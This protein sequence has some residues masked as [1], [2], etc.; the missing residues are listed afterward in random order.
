MKLE[1]GCAPRKRETKLSKK[2]KERGTTR[3][4][5]KKGEK[6]KRT[7]SPSTTWRSP[8]GTWGWRA[9]RSLLDVS[10]AAAVGVRERELE[11]K[12]RRRVARPAVAAFRRRRLLLSLSFLA[13][14][15]PP[16]LPLSPPSSPSSLPHFPSS[17][18]LRPSP[19]PP[20]SLA[21]RG[22]NLRQDHSG[23]AQSGSEASAARRQSASGD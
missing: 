20:S 1:R 5:E 15:S 13:S 23:G 8:P 3:R 12:R 14:T 17:L 21:L 19:K 10:L 11:W 7:C 18:P 2:K 4:V 6:K 16:L 22:K 9:L